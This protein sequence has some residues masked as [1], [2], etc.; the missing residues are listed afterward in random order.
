[1]HIHMNKFVR[2]WPR[3]N[4]FCNDMPNKAVY[5]IAFEC[6]LC[7]AGAKR[8]L[9]D[10][11]FGLV[12]LG[13]SGWIPQL[14]TTDFCELIDITPWQKDP[15]QLRAKWGKESSWSRV[16]SVGRSQEMRRRRTLLPPRIIY[17]QGDILSFSFEN[18]KM[19]PCWWSNSSDFG[20]QMIKLERFWIAEGQT[21]TIL[22]CRR[23][24]SSDFGLQRV[25]PKRFWVAEGQPQTIL[26]CRGSNSRDLGLQRVKLKRFWV[27]E[28]QTR[29]I[30]GCRGSN[31]SD[32]GLQKVKLKRF[33]SWEIRY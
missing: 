12:M 4:A 6:S 27:A 14:P 22:D 16:H 8:C 21:Q 7:T 33:R 32:F 25:K 18:D 23:S 31:S 20:L 2:S 11:M 9:G 29:A 24:N 13:C 26:G 30:L 10:S 28:D 15:K 17:Q 5:Q 1:M 19:S 3:A